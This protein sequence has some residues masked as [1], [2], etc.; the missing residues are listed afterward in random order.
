MP[1]V[2][3]AHEESD[4]VCSIC[5]EPLDAPHSELAKLPCTHSFHLHCISRWIGDNSSC[6]NC[7]AFPTSITVYIMSRHRNPREQSKR[8][9]HAPLPKRDLPVGDAGL[10][11]SRFA[12]DALLSAHH[13]AVLR[14]FRELLVGSAPDAALAGMEARSGLELRSR[15]VA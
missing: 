1:G 15:V 12:P 7:R 8:A 4:S 2:K 10:Y 14:T 13:R 5:L 3:R 9:V 11:G 6:P